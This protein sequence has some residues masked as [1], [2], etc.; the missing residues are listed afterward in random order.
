MPIRNR[1][2]YA[3]AATLAFTVVWGAVAGQEKQQKEPAKPATQGGE[4]AGK[5]EKAANPAQIEL[6]ETK[7]RFE[8]NG[9][10]RKEV[11]ALVKI[12][13]ELGVR[14]FA[15]LN[16]DFNRSFES[17]EIPLVHITHSTGGS[18]DMLPSA[19]TDQPDPAVVNA[20][21]YQDVR[22]KS[23]RILGLEPGDTLEYRVIKTVAHHPLA[24][25][26]WL[27]HT[28]DRTGVVSREV[29]ELDL[30]GDVHPSSTMSGGLG[31]A[32]PMVYA[33]FPW[34]SSR[35]TGDA[36]SARS[37]YRWEVDGQ[38]A[39]SAPVE[40]EGALPVPDLVVTTFGSWSHLASR[41]APQ[42]PDW[43][44]QD[45]KEAL[46]RVRVLDPGAQGQEKRLRAGYEFVSQKLVT[47]DLPIGATGF[48]MRKASEILNS[49]YATPEEKCSLLARFADLTGTPA[50]L[51]FSTSAAAPKQ[52]PRP[53][54]FTHAFV[55]IS[56]N[57]KRLALDPSVE[58]APFGYIAS[59][60][61][62][63]RAFTPTPRKAGEVSYEPWTDLPADLPFPAWQHV[64]VDASLA[65][66]G[67]LTAKLKYNLRGD[68]EM[69]LRLA[70]H[71]TAKE[72]WRD[73]AQL[74]SITDGFRG[75]VSQVTASDP[76]ATREPFTIE[77]EITVPKFVDWAKKPVHLPALLPQVGLPD[78]PARAAL[79]A[80]SPINLGTPLEVETQMTL[81]L[82]PGTSA[83]TPT[84]TIV[85]RDYATYASQ[86]STKESTLKA[87]RR[88]HFL[89]R[90]IPGTRA[91]DYNAFLRAVQSD[92]AQDFTLDK[93]VT[94]PT[95]RPAASNK[96]S[97][98]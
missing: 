84:G 19:V 14:Q 45:G 54:A 74:L 95:T 46:E 87:S 59:Q 97:L 43:T 40:G 60:F 5:S 15:R 12:N 88:I 6:L 76:S 39:L 91:A 4:K 41:L 61:R 80:A 30:P 53:S 36:G 81:R 77:Y 75:Q 71:Q 16:F 58:V 11:H 56:E 72:K 86:Y 94:A 37:E 93:P 10:S 79:G 33:K 47:I 13:S 67:E 57:R 90:E 78:P 96:P 62:G 65:T 31:S 32:G 70:F 73:V 82:P 55:V 68:S 38:H 27:D 23:V 7:V 24:P 18:A 63:H 2:K 1:Q 29:F 64:T 83:T 22:V 48:R 28:F 34:T 66:G 85:E 69:L 50:E 92:A 8:A 9:D 52:L 98:K 25:D 42:F 49:S 20:P 35:H 21:A 17:A 44:E 3:A 89:L 51:L 26:F